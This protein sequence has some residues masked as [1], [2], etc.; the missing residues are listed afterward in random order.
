MNFEKPSSIPKQESVPEHK[1][2][3]PSIEEEGMRDYENPEAMLRRLENTWESIVVFGN[4][5]LY[6]KG[7]LINRRLREER[8]KLKELG[9][10]EE[11]LSEPDVEHEMRKEFTSRLQDE[12]GMLEALL[13]AQL[14]RYDKIEEIK[15]GV[16]KRLGLGS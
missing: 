8:V 4:P 1:Y 10:S 6:E 2:I 16:H 11:T 14:G 5:G 9:V 12:F 3:K 13:K 15:G 7:N